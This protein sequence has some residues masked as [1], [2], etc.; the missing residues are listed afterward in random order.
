MQV[1]PDRST[2]SDEA[3]IESECVTGGASEL[4]L[5]AFD[6]ELLAFVIEAEHLVKGRRHR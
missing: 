1:Y 5:N 2:V 3:C 4:F 6:C